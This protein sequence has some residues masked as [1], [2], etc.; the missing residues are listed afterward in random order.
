MFR[1]F[2][3]ND[4]PL[5]I[6]YWKL[7]TKDNPKG[8]I[9]KVTGDVRGVSGFVIGYMFDRVKKPY[10]AVFMRWEDLGSEYFKP[11]LIPMHYIAKEWGDDYGNL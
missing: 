7:T 9:Y 8:D 1:S 5:G 11:H 10:T 2:G 6:K 3:P 4:Y